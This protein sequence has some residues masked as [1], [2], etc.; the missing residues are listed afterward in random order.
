MHLISNIRRKNR[1]KRQKIFYSLALVSILAIAIAFLLPQSA[2]DKL[3]TIMDW[4]G[5]HFQPADLLLL[6]P[7]CAMTWISLFGLFI[8]PKNFWVWFLSILLL[9]PVVFLL[10]I[11]YNLSFDV[12]YTLKFL[13]LI[14]SFGLLKL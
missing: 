1:Y 8:V 9:I 6:L 10:I 13:V 14:L 5:R 4:N 3:N 7:F 11:T 2:Q 12:L